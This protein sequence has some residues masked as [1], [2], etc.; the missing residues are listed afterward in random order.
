LRAG[1]RK[2]AAR[3]RPDSGADSKGGRPRRT[4]RRQ[5]TTKARDGWIRARSPAACATTNAVP[6]R[7][8]RA[9]WRH[10]RP[11]VIPAANACRVATAASRSRVSQPR[12]SC[13]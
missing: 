1:S 3:L 4:R 5:R 9:G 13:F 11:G 2:P 10:A 8:S 12:S 6:V 7:Q